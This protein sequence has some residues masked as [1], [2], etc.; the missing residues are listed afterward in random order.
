M[1]KIILASKSPRRIELLKMCQVEFRS[2]VADIDEDAIKDQVLSESSGQDTFHIADRLTKKLAYEK[3][4]AI[5]DHYPDAIVIGSDT[6]VVTYN[7]IL[8]KPKD[9]DDAYNMLKDLSGQVHRVYTGVSI[10]GPDH[11]YNFTNFA[12]VRFYDWD[13]NMENIVRDY[14]AT[15]SP[16]DKAGAYGIQDMGALLVE[17]IDGDYYT[18]MGLPIAQLY[19]KL[20]IL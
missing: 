20:K 17:S 12:Q 18:I 10:I 1:N 15:G 19:R 5:H 13:S 2:M 9:Q 11:E 16:M 7:S 8:G 14:I 6:L 4:K 3:A